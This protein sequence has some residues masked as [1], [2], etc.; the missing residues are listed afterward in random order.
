MY[1][2]RLGSRFINCYCDRHSR[3][4]IN[5]RATTSKSRY[6]ISCWT[7]SDFY[8]F[9]YLLE[10]MSARIPSCV[11]VNLQFYS[12]TPL[13]SQELFW[14]KISM[15]SRTLHDTEPLTMKSTVK[16]VF[17]FCCLTLRAIIVY[18]QGMQFDKRLVD[19]KCNQTWLQR[20]NQ[21]TIRRCQ[22]NE[23]RCSGTER[24]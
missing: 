8:F 6:S 14:S 22:R 19:S 7:Y 9:Y 21:S 23:R 4:H 16:H 24:M 13:L 2:A 15:R 18:P 5:L 10:R 17:K 12:K 3:F 11:Q 1:L 20:Q